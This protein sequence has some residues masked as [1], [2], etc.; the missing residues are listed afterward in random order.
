MDL[1]F[2][3]DQGVERHD[4]ADIAALLARDQGFVWVDVPAWG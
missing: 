2:V 3:H 4:H 1:W